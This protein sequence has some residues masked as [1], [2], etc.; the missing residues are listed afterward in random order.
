MGSFLTIEKMEQPAAQED[1]C[2]T[3]SCENNGERQADLPHQLERQSGIIPY[4]PAKK[5]IDKDPGR[6]LACGHKDHA[7]AHLLPERRPPAR[8]F[9]LLGA[10]N[11]TD[12]AQYE[13]G[14]VGK[15]PEK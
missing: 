10:E 12:S 4:V 15:A 13:H 8:P 7:P 3:Q 9:S 11:H 1:A 2:G 5:L 14:P 6:K